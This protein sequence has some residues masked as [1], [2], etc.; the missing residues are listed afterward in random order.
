MANEPSVPDVTEALYWLT[1]EVPATRPSENSA[2]MD[3][4]AGIGS[5]SAQLVRFQ[6]VPSNEGSS[7]AALVAAGAQREQGDQ[8]HGETQDASRTLRHA[9]MM[10][11]GSAGPGAR[12]APE[13]LV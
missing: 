10:A 6:R 13:T 3:A 5:G 12:R 1:P 9:R 11:A 7:L 2:V 4:E 8:H